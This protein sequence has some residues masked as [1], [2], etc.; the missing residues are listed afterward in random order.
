MRD[1]TLI[2]GGA[3]FIGCGLSRLL[4]PRDKPIVAIDNLHEQVHRSRQRPTDLA[5]E[6][7]LLVGDVCDPAMWDRFLTDHRPNTV[8][9]LA[10]E[11]GTAQSLTEATRH[12][13]VNVVGTTQMLDAFTRAGITPEHIVL[14]SSR[15]IYGEGAWANS[16]GKIFYPAPRSHQ[17]LERQEWGFSWDGES[18]QAV[19]HR[20]GRIFP[21]PSSI[22]GATK[23]AQEHIVSAWATAMKVPVSI[24]RLQNVYGPGQSPF[25]PY[26]GIIN[27]F[28]RVA[29]AGGKID[30]YEDGLIGRD[31]VYIDDVL[32]AIVAAVDTPP[33]ALRTLDVGTG[34]P[35]TI[36]EAAEHIAK[37][38]RAPQPVISG[39]FRDGDVRW[40]VADPQ[41]LAEDLNVRSEV[42]FL[43]SGAR[44]VGEWLQA[45]GFMQ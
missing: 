5:G 26:T 35:T 1:V 27:I 41:G 30:V 15:A 13:Q 8:I 32:R 38:H 18:L 20:A 24:L 23:L 45:K 6:V 43:N 10:A 19:A 16:D 42:D 39:K 3:G 7:E 2:T 31:F 11:T 12:S 36:L 44:L 28:H 9:H 25:N 4:G 33:K 21:A 40:A 29:Y 17:Q 14:T 37:L 34:R 22:Y